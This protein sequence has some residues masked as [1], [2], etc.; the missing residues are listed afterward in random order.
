MPVFWGFNRISLTQTPPI[1]PW[2]R[3]KTFLKIKFNLHTKVVKGAL[4]R[5]ELSG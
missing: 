2:L 1:R 3:E 4:L 5:V